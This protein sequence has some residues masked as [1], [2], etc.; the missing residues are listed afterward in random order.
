M[1]KQA[2]RKTKAEKQQAAEP[3]NIARDDKVIFESFE[4]PESS[5][6]ASAHYDVDGGKMTIKFRRGPGRDHD[7]YDYTGI[8]ADLWSQFASAE[9]K[10]KFF[11][12]QI[13]PLYAGKPYAG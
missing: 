10:G 4:S 13:R 7:R 12:T 1:A 2:K 3:L 9:S 5:T 11:S 8:P 6:I